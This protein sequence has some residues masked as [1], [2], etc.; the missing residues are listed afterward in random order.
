MLIKLVTN[1]HPGL[2][3]ANCPF[4]GDSTSVLNLDQK[5]GTF[6]LLAFFCDCTEWL[7]SDM[8]GNPEDHFSHVKRKSDFD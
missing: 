8:V 5:P 6:K 3:K 7:M 2:T 4:N 1:V